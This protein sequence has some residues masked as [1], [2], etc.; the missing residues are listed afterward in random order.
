M[1]VFS[2]PGVTLTS[3]GTPTNEFTLAP[4][5]TYYP[6]SNQNPSVP[7]QGA[8]QAGWFYWG[9]GRYTALQHKDPISGIWRDSGDDTVCERYFYADGVNVR[10]A[11]QSGCAVSA[12]VTNAGSGY[13]TAPTVVASAGGSVWQAILGPLVSTTVTITY[14]GSNYLY[15]PNVVIQS[16]P[17]AG[18]GVQAT[19]Y[20]SITNGVVT[21]I[22][23]TNQGAGYNGGVP[24]IYLVNDPRDTTGSG[25]QAVATLT[26]AGTVAAV[27]SLDHGNPVSSVPTLTF[28]SGSAAATALMYW[29]INAYAVT[30]AGA[31]YTSAASTIL[32]SAVGP[33]AVSGAVYTNPSIQQGLIAVRQASLW[34][35]TNSSGALLTGGQII[36]GGVY[37][38]T[39][40]PIYM[41]AQPAT[42]NGVLTYTMGGNYDT[43]QLQAF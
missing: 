11:N 14:G 19:G 34:V 35:P 13:V 26:G 18:G 9:G 7:G 24:L 38:G 31:G 36:D 22:T 43:W 17:P 8:G 21:S 28:G 12:V 16:P 27:V 41:S 1:A 3:K 15:P 30:T 2:G 25:A 29:S 6:G 39:P 5:A 23:I 4:G 33:A 42:T 37:L 40:A 10:L 20:A 32:A